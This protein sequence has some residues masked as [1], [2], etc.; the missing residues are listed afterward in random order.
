VQVGAVHLGGAAGQVCQ[1]VRVRVPVGVVG[2]DRHD[3]HPGADRVEEPGGV[4]VPAVVRDLEDRGSQPFRAAQ[5]PRLRDLLGV[6]REQRARRA[7]DP[8]HERVGVGPPAQ[9][10]FDRRRQDLDRL[11]AERERLPRGDP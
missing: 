3:R 4:G 8:Q 1:H 11:G 5:E 2:A 6:T 7:P 9:R 10:R